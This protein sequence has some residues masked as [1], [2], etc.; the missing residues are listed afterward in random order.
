M[1]VKPEVFL[2]RVCGVNRA[3]HFYQPLRKVL[4]LLA[5]RC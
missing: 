2:V 1:Y 5:L 3:Q 4:I